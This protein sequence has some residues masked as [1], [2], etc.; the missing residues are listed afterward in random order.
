MIKSSHASPRPDG[1]TAISD[2][3]GFDGFVREVHAETK[4]LIQQQVG[5]YG[6]PDKDDELRLLI[7]DI[8]F[9]V[10]AARLAP[11]LE[12]LFDERLA[13]IAQE[14]LPLVRH[15]AAVRRAFEEIG[16]LPGK[17]ALAVLSEIFNL[18]K[19]PEGAE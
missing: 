2:A 4:R 16:S 17:T 6:M 1:L 7:W 8:T 9:E 13:K 15:N 18:D 5:A 11:D 10:V 19:K 14:C 12:R 3:G